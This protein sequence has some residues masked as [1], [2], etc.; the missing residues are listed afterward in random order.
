MVRTSRR[1]WTRR[2]VARH[3]R[4]IPRPVEPGGPQRF[5]LTYVRSGPRSRLPIVV[6]P[7][8]PG[9]ASVLPYRSFRALAAGRGLDVIM[10]EHR[11]VGLSGRTTAGARLPEAALSVELAADDVAAVLDDTAVERAVIV[12]SS[13]GSYLAQAVAVRHPERVEALVLDSPLLSVAADLAVTRAYWRALLWRGDTSA[14]AGIAGPLRHLVAAGEPWDALS[15]VVQVTYELAGPAT[16]ERLLR[17]R[18][19][20]RLGG[21]WNG[22]ARLAVDLEH[23]RIPFWSEPD[24]VAG[25]AYRQLGFGLPPDGH[26]LD[27]QLVLAREAERRPRYAGE[28]FDFAAEA[29]RYPWP[30][31][32]VSGDRDLRTP[33]PIAE[34][35]VGLAPR[36]VLVRLADTGH[37]ALD[38]HQRALLA[39][40]EATLEDPGALPLL[41]Q[42]LSAAPR[43]GASV[44]PGKALGVAVRAGARPLP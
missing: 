39:V 20:G 40:I 34:R 2:V 7:G 6:A 31:V 18:L 4:S 15:A 29:P 8:G 14:T 30:T 27:P 22:L 11:G 35:I 28:P 3:G 21:L 16:L 5:P 41:E 37:S 23:M 10:V 17:A 44:L 25:I 36:G 24:A 1:G 12:G 33:P 13:Y 43:K 38:T 26:P 32:V 42:Q 19:D 9:L